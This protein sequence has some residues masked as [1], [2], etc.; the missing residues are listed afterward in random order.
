MPIV[1]TSL[2]A[3]CALAGAWLDM[4]NRRLPNWL[5]LVTVLTGLAMAFAHDGAG[6]LVSPGLHA[7]L[8]LVMGMVLFRIGWIGGGDAKFY[9]ACAAWFPL[10]S[11]LYL[12]G[13]VSLAG[14]V[15]VSLWFGWRQL[16][17]ARA[18]R[19]GDAFAMVP[20]GL[21]VAMGAV[22]LKVCAP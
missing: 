11:G 20:Y 3:L 19:R 6:A 21:A 9:A 10:A 14:L 1:A 4:A 22:A 17:R 18:R 2:L 13:A 7:A 12:L 8:A 16:T 5:C 15:V